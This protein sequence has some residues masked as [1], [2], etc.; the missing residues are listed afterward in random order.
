MKLSYTAKALKD[1]RKMPSKDRTAIMDKL[2]AFVETGQ[3]AVKK[4]Q[5]QPFHRMRHGNWRAILTL[6]NGVLVVRVLHRSK[7]YD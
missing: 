5:G 6:D 2:E 3:G 4:L 1:L 7:A